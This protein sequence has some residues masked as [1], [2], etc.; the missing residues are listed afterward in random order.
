MGNRLGNSGPPEIASVIQISNDCPILERASARIAC[1][2][3]ILQQLV[4][5]RRHKQFNRP[6]EVAFE[7][8]HDGAL[9]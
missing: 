3:A 7:S 9:Y 5:V 6:Y 4:L 2:M 1:V 8:C